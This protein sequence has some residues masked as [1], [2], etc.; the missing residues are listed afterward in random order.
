MQ[1]TIQIFRLGVLQR[2]PRSIVLSLRR[3]PWIIPLESFVS[4]HLKLAIALFC[5]GCSIESASSGSVEIVCQGNSAADST[6]RWIIDFE[7]GSL[8]KGPE[9][10]IRVD[11]IGET[12][13]SNFR[14]S[15]WQ[16]SINRSNG[17]YTKYHNAAKLLVRGRCARR[18]DAF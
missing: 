10:D 18:T 3:A 4:Q 1:H 8:I 7:N 15:I 12:G 2:F 9:R 17:E 13:W 16:Y 6:D 11:N 5:L 14:G